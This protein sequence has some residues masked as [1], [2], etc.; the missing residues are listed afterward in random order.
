[1]KM[2]L[3]MLNPDEEMEVTNIRKETK[4]GEPFLQNIK[5]WW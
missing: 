1:M 3:M 4:G 5:W 2:I